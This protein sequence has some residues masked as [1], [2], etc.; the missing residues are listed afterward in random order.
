M[1]S[2]NRFACFL[3]NHAARGFIGLPGAS[4]SDVYVCDLTPFF[5]FDDPGLFLV[6]CVG[7][8]GA[9]ELS[10]PAAKR[11]APSFAACADDVSPRRQPVEAINASVVRFRHL[12]PK[13]PL[14]VALLP[15]PIHCV[16]LYT[17]RN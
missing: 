4:E 14:G 17:F 10:A 1:A 11:I 2:G 5:D 16:K 6:G 15:L 9:R 8:I 7:M 12:V 3:I 13:V